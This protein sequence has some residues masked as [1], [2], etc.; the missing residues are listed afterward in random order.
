MFFITYFKVSAVCPIYFLPQSLQVSWQVQPLWNLFRPSLED[1][2]IFRVFLDSWPLKIDPTG[3]PE[4]S[5]RK[6]HSSLR[7]S[8]EGRSSHPARSCITEHLVLYATRGVDFLKRSVI[9]YV[10]FPKKGKVN[11]FYFSF[12]RLS[13]S[14]IL[15]LSLYRS[16]NLVTNWIGKELYKLFW[17]Y[18][19]LA[20]F[21]NWYVFNPSLKNLNAANIWYKGWHEL[22]GII[23][24]NPS[25]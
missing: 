7:N 13:S 25:L 5:V 22:K 16:K 3:C 15:I 23:V 9:Q 1:F 18:C 10:S 8:P 4:T 17:M 12:K 6:Y 14:F 21:F 19:L 20:S 24:F 2:R 11:H